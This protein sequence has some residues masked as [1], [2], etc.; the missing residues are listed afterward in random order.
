[1]IELINVF[2]S[3][4]YEPVSHDNP[5]IKKSDGNTEIR[6]SVFIA[7]S[8]PVYKYTRILRDQQR[9]EVYNPRAQ[10]YRDFSFC[11]GRAADHNIVGLRT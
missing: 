7:S 9:C 11:L 8:L 4:F 2:V 5:F 10:I 6:L 1:M 3:V